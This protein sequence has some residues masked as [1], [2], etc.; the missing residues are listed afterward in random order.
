MTTPPSVDCATACRN[1]CILGDQCPHRDSA[2]QAVD[3]I[4][5]TDWDTLM[6]KAET[7]AQADPLGMLDNY[8][9]SGGN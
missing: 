5:N 6:Q 1:G 2:R 8:Q 9:V 4:M 3:Y 7:Q